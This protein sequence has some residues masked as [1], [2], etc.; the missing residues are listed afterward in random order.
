VGYYCG[1]DYCAR[2]QFCSMVSRLKFAEQH[3]IEPFI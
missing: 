3:L 2:H 1:D